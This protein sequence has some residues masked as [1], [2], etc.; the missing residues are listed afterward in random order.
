MTYL[1]KKLDHYERTLPGEIMN[2]NLVK[3]ASIALM[4]LSLT[5]V[6]QAQT[7]VFEDNFNNGNLANSDTETGY[8][9]STPGGFTT[10]TEGSGTFQADAPSATSGSVNGDLA[11]ILDSDLSFFTTAKTFSVRLDGDG[12][13]GV[14]STA[15]DI[16]K[17]VRFSVASSGTSLTASDI[18]TLRIDAGKQISLASRNDYTGA[19]AVADAVGGGTMLLALQTLSDTA[20]AITGFD[21]TLNAT[22]FTLQMYQGSSFTATQIFTGSHLLTESSWDASGQAKALFRTTRQG[23]GTGVSMDLD[24]ESFVVT[25]AAIPEPNSLWFLG[26]GFLFLARRVFRIRD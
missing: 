2:K 5:S 23:G 9:T 19:G 15:N 12:I 22:N 13:N 18:I 6:I 3:R 1:T 11:G 14:S 21:L 8:W 7:V 4:A 17:I 24:V 25:A 16:R 10:F 20:N 26:C